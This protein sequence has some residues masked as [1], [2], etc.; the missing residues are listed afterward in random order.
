MELSW[1]E[2][3]VRIGLKSVLMSF[4]LLAS[5]YWCYI[6][7][8]HILVW[9]TCSRFSSLVFGIEQSAD[10]AVWMEFGSLYHTFSKG[11]LWVLKL[12]NIAICKAPFGT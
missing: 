1:E 11:E 3:D 4:R 5:K 2:Y 9:T 8:L 12:L 6:V 10:G 7:L